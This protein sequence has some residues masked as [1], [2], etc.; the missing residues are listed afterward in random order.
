[1]ASSKEMRLT[2]IEHIAWEASSWEITFFSAYLKKQHKSRDK[3][4]IYRQIS[5]RNSINLSYVLHFYVYFFFMASQFAIGYSQHQSQR[6]WE[7]QIY[8]KQGWMLPLSII[9]SKTHIQHRPSVSK[10]KSYICEQHINNTIS[11]KPQMQIAI[12]V[13]T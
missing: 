13:K 10:P 2:C 5:R 3:G 1:M 7:K 12:P 8:K 6:I 11:R 4:Y 9:L